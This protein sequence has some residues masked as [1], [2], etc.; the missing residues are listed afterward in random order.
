MLLHLLHLYVWKYDIGWND[1]DELTVLSLILRRHLQQGCVTASWSERQS[2]GALWDRMVILVD[3]SLILVS[4]S[5]TKHC[6]SGRWENYKLTWDS[7]RRLED[8]SKQKCQRVAWQEDR[9]REQTLPVGN[10]DFKSFRKCRAEVCG[11]S[12]AGVS[13]IKPGGQNR[14][15]KDYSWPDRME[16]MKEGINLSPKNQADRFPSFTTAACSW[17]CMSFF[18]ISKYFRDQMCSQTSLQRQKGEFHWSDPLQVT[19][20]CLWFTMQNEFDIPVFRGKVKASRKDLDK[21]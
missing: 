10:C 14:P 5:R 12:T 17:N 15:V 4:I 7:T 16:N 11:D 1:P 3:L 13:N 2:V 18:P 19:A 8:P 20:S 6:R 9:Q 21:S